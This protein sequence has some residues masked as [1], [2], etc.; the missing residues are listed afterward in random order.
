MPDGRY[1]SKSGSN[2]SI[3]RAT[4]GV[5]STGWES[6][7]RDW[8]SLQLD[9]K[10]VEGELKTLDGPSRDKFLESAKEAT[11]RLKA[12]IGSG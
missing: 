12:I 6:F 2:E 8:E 10:S 9:W 3:D 1:Y 4:T 7:K 5:F 11:L